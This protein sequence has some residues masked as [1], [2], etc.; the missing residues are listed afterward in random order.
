M[1]DRSIGTARRGTAVR[2]GPGE[3]LVHHGEM[4]RH[5]YAIRSGEVLVTASSTSGATRAAVIRALRD[6]EADGVVTLRRGAVELKL[7]G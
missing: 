7:T 5:C 4:T 1:W 2:F 3:V 6:L